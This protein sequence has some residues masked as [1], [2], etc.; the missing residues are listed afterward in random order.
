MSAALDALTA[1]TDAIRSANHATIVTA[2]FDDPAEVYRLLGELGLLVHRLP[3]LVEQLGRIIGG[4]LASGDL[5][6]D[7]GSPFELADIA[8]DTA[9]GHLDQAR[10]Y[11]PG[12]ATRLAAAQRAMSTV[13]TTAEVTR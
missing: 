10:K 11:L 9:R 6:V 8:A 1:A 4:Q 3:Q 5:A 12:I 2:A 7:E 13:Y